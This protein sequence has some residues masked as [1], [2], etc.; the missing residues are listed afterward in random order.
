MENKFFSG[1]SL[2]E[3]DETEISYLPFLVSNLSH[4]YISFAK[5]RR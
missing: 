2:S 1:M 3:L 4:S 5:P